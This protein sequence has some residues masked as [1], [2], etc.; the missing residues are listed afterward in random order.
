VEKQGWMM[1]T[2]SSMDQALEALF[3]GKT[4]I[5]TGAAHGFGRA[6]SAEMVRR[7]ATVVAVDVVEKE[8]EETL[9][10]G[11]RVKAYG[12]EVVIRR[13]DVTRE[14]EI[15]A[16]VDWTISRCGKIDIL[17]NNA[18]GV[19]G[20]VHKPVET[21]TSAEWA[22]IIDVNLNGVFYFIRAVSAPMKKRKYGRI[23]NV[24]SGAGRSYSLTGIQAYASAKAGQIGLT[25]QM[26]RELGNFNI[27]VNNV[28]PGFVRSNPST[29]E[30]WRNMGEQNQRA[31]LE[32][33]SLHRLGTAE[34]IAYAVL[35]FAS[36][37]A[38][39]ISGQVISVDGGQQ[40][41]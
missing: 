39:Y 41:F 2:Q 20:Q 37:Y 7:G 33:I 22:R 5:V 3:A 32:S 34:E 18:G 15:Q 14:A 23:V 11:N 36:D 9:A 35:F 27:T 24:S 17:V 1:S 29:E 6:I 8:L 4:A 12:G 25:R 13:V 16:C 19:L 10:A 31:L 28:A 40:M 38:G 26:A 30:Q 21:V